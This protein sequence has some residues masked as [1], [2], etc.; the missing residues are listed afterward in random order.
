MADKDEAM[1]SAFILLAKL[2]Q[3]KTI[4]FGKIFF[5]KRKKILLVKNIDFLLV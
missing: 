5:K 1:N 3:S 4:F 2:L